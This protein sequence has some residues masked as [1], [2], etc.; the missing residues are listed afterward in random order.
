MFSMN[1]YLISCTTVHLKPYAKERSLFM[2]IQKEST[3]IFLHEHTFGG[4]N[5]FDL[6]TTVAIIVAI[7]ALRT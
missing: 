2:A 7:E 5:T 1:I 6:V 3:P 4:P